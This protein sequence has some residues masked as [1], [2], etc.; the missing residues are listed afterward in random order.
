M[1]DIGSVSYIPATEE[2]RTLINE[3][4][5]YELKEG[6]ALSHPVYSNSIPADLIKVR[7]LLMID[8]EIVGEGSPVTLGTRQNFH[9]DFNHPAMT[10]AGEEQFTL[11][12]GA[13]HV[14]NFDIGQTGEEHLNERLI[15]LRELVRADEIQMAQKTREL[16]YM[17]SQNYYE[18]FNSC[19]HLLEQ[20]YNIKTILKSSAGL[21]SD[22]LKIKWDLSGNPVMAEAGGFSMDLPRNIVTA[23]SVV[24]DE[25]SVRKFN[26]INGIMSSYLEGDIF[27]QLFDE[28][29]KGFEADAVSTIHILKKALS[30]GINIY[31]INEENMNE[32]LSKLDYNTEQLN[33]FKSYI[34]A[35]RELT[36]PQREINIGNW[37]GIGYIVYHESGTGAYMI[38]GGQAG[39]FIDYVLSLDDPPEQIIESLERIL[40]Y[41]SERDNYEEIKDFFHEISRQL[42]VEHAK[43][44]TETEYNYVYG[45][46]YSP[47]EE[48]FPAGIEGYWVDDNGIIELEEPGI[49][50]SGFTQRIYEE[51]GY[52]FDHEA[53]NLG[54]AAQRNYFKNPD[55]SEECLIRDEPEVGG[56][57][58]IHPRI[59]CDRWIPH[60]AIVSEVDEEGNVE[61][62]IDSGSGPGNEG[63]ALTEREPP[64]NWYDTDYRRDEPEYIGL[65]DLIDVE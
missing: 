22:G 24:G 29:N 37:S 46:K 60:I 19:K 14:I 16:L 26:L 45:G 33:V 52:E 5:N 34:E 2:D 59:S 10:D 47:S 7:P 21:T 31:D 36:V 50:C 55:E 11:T 1:K 15:T 17:V 48:A 65:P 63:D 38:S 42:T 43:G 53:H 20:S 56:L 8:E 27:V 41:F 3:Y 44:Y 18:Q 40:N 62:V 54:A 32:V 51:M 64:D 28:D 13:N 25:E 49:D 23:H 6:E 9:L 57:M 30:K 39:G 58:Y 35:G 4:S 61:K 12:V